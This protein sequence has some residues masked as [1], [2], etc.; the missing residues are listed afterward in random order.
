DFR[1]ALQEDG[2]ALHLQAGEVTHGS[3]HCNDASLHPH[4]DFHACR[5]VDD[6]RAPVH[7]GRA[8]TVGGSDLSAR[9]AVNLDEPAGHLGTDPVRGVAMY[10]DGAAFHVGPKVHAGI[11]ND[12]QS[13]ARH[14]ATEPAHLSGISTD[15]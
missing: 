6:D 9:I 3:F 13:P 15:F 8:S 4:A 2:A 10:L 14:A 7:A 1:P 11:A 12:G 5:S